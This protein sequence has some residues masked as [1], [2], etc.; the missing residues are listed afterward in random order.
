MKKKILIIA[1]SIISVLVLVTSF[2]IS[3]TGLFHLTEIPEEENEPESKSSKW[4]M[5]G[6]VSVEDGSVS[7]L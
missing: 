4:K 6:N 7:N 1:V 5:I 3:H 2:G